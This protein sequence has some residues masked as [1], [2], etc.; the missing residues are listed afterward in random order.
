MQN[1]HNTK[2]LMAIAVERWW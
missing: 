2:V 1:V